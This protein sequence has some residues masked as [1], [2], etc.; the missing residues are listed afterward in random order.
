VLI[1]IFEDSDA[2]LPYVGALMSIAMVSKQLQQFRLS[3]LV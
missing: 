3:R 1:R 2:R